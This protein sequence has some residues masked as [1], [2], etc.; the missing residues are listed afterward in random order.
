MPDVLTQSE[1]KPAPRPE[2]TNRIGLTADAYKGAESTLCSGCGHDSITSQIIKACYETGIQPYNVAKMSG[3]GCSSKTPAY[4]LSKSHGFNAVHGR[5][6][7]GPACPNLTNPPMQ[8]I[9]APRAG[10]TAPF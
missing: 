6:P 4:F 2:K 7:A 1:T 5:M 9:G 8:V 10:P 3:I